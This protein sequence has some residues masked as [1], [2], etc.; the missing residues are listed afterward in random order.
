MLKI[1]PKAVTSA[2]EDEESTVTQPKAPAKPLG[3]KPEALLPK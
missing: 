2:S 3:M 1:S